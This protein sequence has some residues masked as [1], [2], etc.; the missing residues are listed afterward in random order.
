MGSAVRDGIRDLGRRSRRRT[1]PPTPAPTRR[2]GLLDLLL[3]VGVVLLAGTRTPV[4]GLVHYGVEKARG[5]DTELPSLTAWFDSGAAAPPD[6]EHL[7]LAHP[8]P[9]PD[10][11]L[12]EP[13]RTAARTVLAE[14][15][16]RVAERL[17][18]REDLPEEGRTMAVLDE[19]YAD[20]PEAALELLVL[21]HELRDRAIRRA[22]AA[23]EP[24]PTTYAAHRRYLPPGVAADADR[25]VNGTLALA[26]ALDLAW[27]VRTKHRVSSPFG[28]RHHPVLKTKKFHN[29]IDLAVPIG[30]PIHAPQ[31]GTVVTVGE[32]AASGRFVIVDHGHGLRTTYCHLSASRVLR[33]A[34][35]KRGQLL[36]DSGNTG[37][38]TGPHLHW[39]VRIAGKP[40]DPARFDRRVPDDT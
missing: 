17:A 35:V 8:D 28:Y 15:P 14:P 21:G 6:L 30:T 34:R 31:D 40:V 5:T 39:I 33:G 32:N 36:A 23:G 4:G 1:L 13:W 7:E 11:G 38:S 20:D 25:V 26:S 37:R 18:T 12:P 22:E 24:E 29:G 10:G 19:L 9:I 3:V 16:K 2:G 27:P